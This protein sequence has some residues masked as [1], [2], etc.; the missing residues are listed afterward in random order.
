MLSFVP[1]LS[2]PI[3]KL[4]SSAEYPFPTCPAP[5]EPP[6][7]DDAEHPHSAQ[8]LREPTEEC[9]KIIQMGAPLSMYCSLASTNLTENPKS[10]VRRRTRLLYRR[11]NKPTP[12]SWMA[13][14]ML[15]PNGDFHRVIHHRNLGVEAILD[16]KGQKHLCP[17]SESSVRWCYRCSSPSHYSSANS[18]GCF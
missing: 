3:P 10:A 6:A 14:A 16:K 1:V 4:L 18:L 11:R 15:V 9:V 8:C 2:K 5:T 17:P 12:I 13:T 7:T